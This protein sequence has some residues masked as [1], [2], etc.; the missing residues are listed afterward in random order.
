[1]AFFFFFYHADVTACETASEKD[2]D[3]PEKSTAVS[4]HSP[5]A[6]LI[7]STEIFV[8]LNSSYLLVDKYFIHVFIFFSRLHK[9]GSPSGAEK[10][11]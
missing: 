9:R 7:E 6:V 2:V 10:C 5:C 11:A 8:V 1:M 4:S 3:E